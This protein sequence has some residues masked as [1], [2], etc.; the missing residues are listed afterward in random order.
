MIESGQ[1]KYLRKEKKKAILGHLPCFLLLSNK[2]KH[3]A[4][5]LVPTQPNSL[6]WQRPHP[7][8]PYSQLSSVLVVT[9]TP[10]ARISSTNSA[11]AASKLGT[12]DAQSVSSTSLPRS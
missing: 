6:R 7:K 4:T 8:W 2:D 11:A 10:A 5:W 9:V 1:A 12:A 3:M